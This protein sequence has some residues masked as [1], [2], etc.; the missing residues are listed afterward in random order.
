MAITAAISLSSAAGDLVSSALSV[1]TSAALTKAGAVTKIENTTGLARKTTSYASSGV[2]DT[3]VLFRADDYTN[4]GANKMYLK[5]IS[6][7]ATEYFTVY[8]TGDRGGETHT[9]ADSL[10]EIG[11]L[12]AGDWA[13]FP[14]NATGG[15]KEAFTVTFAATWAAGDTWT[16][17]GITVLAA[18]SG[19]NEMATSVD[20]VQYPNW[21]TTV[22]SA[23]V[24][25]TSRTSRADLEIDTTEAVSTTA[26]DG[27]GAVATTVTGKKS[28]SDIY[29]KPSV[30]TTMDL[31]HML[32]Y[33]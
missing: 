21:T 17:D 9:Y 6:T 33:Q 27:T 15:T 16:F 4:N 14:W 18:G 26:G 24:T 10:I 3:T 8:I 31:E 28:A 5:N 7:T 20:A 11:R 32:F 29:V 2:I 25:F 19:L 12:Y 30:V 22:S 1:S 23:V 13:F